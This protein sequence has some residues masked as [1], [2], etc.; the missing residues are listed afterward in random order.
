MKSLARLVAHRPAFSGVIVATL[1]L[2]IGSATALYSVIDAVLLHPFP[3][4]DQAKL[5]LLW[6]ADLTRN[7]P[8]VEISY[9]DARE[10]QTRARD[11]FDSIASMSSVNFA[12]TVTG[13]GDP[14]QLQVRVVGDPFFETLGAAP[15]LGRTLQAADHRHQ[16]PKVAVVGHGV[17][18]R[19]FGGDPAVVGKTITLDGETHT[20]VGV[21]PRAFQYPEGAELWTPVEQAVDAKALE[22]RGLRLDACVKVRRSIEPAPRSTSSS[23][24]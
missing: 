20:I 4:R 6:Q 23:R 14:Q 8:F 7:H 11:A 9:L 18:Q 13:I 24:A 10:W 19:L 17:W 1:A 21:M 15:A 2:G 22:N 5:A 12:A 16:A 3:F